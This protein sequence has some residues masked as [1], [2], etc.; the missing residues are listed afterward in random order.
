MAL[1]GTPTFAVLAWPARVTKG[2]RLLPQRSRSSVPIAPDQGLRAGSDSPITK[3]PK[4]LPKAPERDHYRADC[5]RN[6]GLPER[7]GA[8]GR[9]GDASREEDAEGQAEQHE[10]ENVDSETLPSVR[11]S[12]GTSTTA[13][14]PIV[15]QSGHTVSEE[16]GS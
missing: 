9:P 4:L 15:S 7:Y 12:A 1:V 3:F 8:V 6:H 13:H 16:R 14:R 11:R 10:N 5:N 2:R